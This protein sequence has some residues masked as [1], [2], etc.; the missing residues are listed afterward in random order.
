MSPGNWR[1]AF[2]GASH[3]TST[4]EQREPLQ[5]GTDELGKATQ[6]QEVSGEDGGPLVIRFVNDWR[7]PHA[8]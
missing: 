3:T 4:L 8:E 6:R 7:Q 2:C 5:I 1:L